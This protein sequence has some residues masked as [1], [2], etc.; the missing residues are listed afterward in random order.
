VKVHKWQKKPCQEEEKG[1][2]INIE[3]KR[4]GGCEEILDKK[5]NKGGVLKK[6]KPAAR[7]HEKVLPSRGQAPRIEGTVTGS[8]ENQ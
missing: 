5:L 4:K 6:T 7:R 3:K 8:E 2:K 1:G